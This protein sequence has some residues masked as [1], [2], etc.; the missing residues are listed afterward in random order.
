MVSDINTPLVRFS[1]ENALLVEKII[2]AY[3]NADGW[4]VDISGTDGYLRP[5]LQEGQDGLFLTPRLSAYQKEV[6]QF[7]EWL[8]SLP[9]DYDFSAQKDIVK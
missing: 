7:A 3:D 5:K 4:E 2:K 1:K 6:R 8:Q 9:D